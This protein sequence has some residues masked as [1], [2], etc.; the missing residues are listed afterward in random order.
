MSLYD[1][2]EGERVVVKN[3][4][5]E[6]IATVGVVSVLGAVLVDENEHRWSKK[7]GKR[8]P[9]NKGIE[10]FVDVLTP[11]ETEVVERGVAEATIFRFYD[12]M[13]REPR[14]SLEHMRRVVAAVESEE[15]PQLK[16]RP[17]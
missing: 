14:P 8:L 4:R 7:D 12:R 3:R 16:P 9:R 2:K 10:T 1:V 6:P 15:L 13:R 11:S 5:G 17:R